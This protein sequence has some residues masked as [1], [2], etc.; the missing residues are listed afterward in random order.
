M[1]I[2]IAPISSI[3]S[4]KITTLTA[5]LNTSF[6]PSEA[7]KSFVFSPSLKLE[8]PLKKKA[9][10]EVNVKIPIPPNCI[11]TN[12]MVCPIIVKSF[13]VFKTDKPVTHTELVA[14]KIAFVNEIPF[15]VALG[16]ISKKAPERAKII[17]LPTK[18]MAGLK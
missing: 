9:K 2:K 15:V 17:K 13:A 8:P 6:N 5:A 16:N 7:I 18:T 1:Y 10:N 11:K 12:I 14:V 4:V 3:E